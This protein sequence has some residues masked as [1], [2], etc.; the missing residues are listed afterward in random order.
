MGSSTNGGIKLTPATK[1]SRSASLREK[2]K[3]ERENITLWKKPLTTLNYSFREFSLTLL[4]WTKQI[5]QHKWTLIFLLIL[6]AISVLLYQVDGPHQKQLLA[7]EKYLLWC[8]WWVGLGK[9]LVLKNCPKFVQKS[10]LFF[11]NFQEFCR[12]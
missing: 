12:R 9:F 5:F 10:E 2:L 8:A 11:F 3:E 6:V 1:R 7:V 4:E